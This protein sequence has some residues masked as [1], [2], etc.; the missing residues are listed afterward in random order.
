MESGVEKKGS[1]QSRES[2]I[3]P[4]FKNTNAFNNNT[5]YLG[6]YGY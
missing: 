6:Y 3:G 1:V 5:V 4:D 2:E